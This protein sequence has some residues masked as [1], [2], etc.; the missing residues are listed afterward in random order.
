MSLK[1]SVYM[2][3]YPSDSQPLCPYFY[4]YIYVA[5]LAVFVSACFSVRHAEFFLMRVRNRVFDDGIQIST[6]DV[7]LI[8]TT[9]IVVITVIAIILSWPS[10]L[11]YGYITILTMI[12][13][14]IVIVF[15]IPKYTFKNSVVLALIHCNI[16]YFKAAIIPI[17]HRRNPVNHPY[18][19]TYVL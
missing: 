4:L 13:E 8:T 19:I 12:I 2:S 9:I 14:I 3:I 5:C 11:N 17:H 7:R 1:L 6:T 18:S 10:P 16:T 15:H